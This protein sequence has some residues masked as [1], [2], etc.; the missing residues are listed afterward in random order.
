VTG[1]LLATLLGYV[2]RA[3]TLQDGVRAIGIGMWLALIMAFNVWFIIWPNQKKALGI[4]V[5]EAAEKAAAAKMA[6]MTSRANTMLSSMLWMMV[7]QQNRG[8]TVFLFS[9]VTAGRA[10]VILRESREQCLT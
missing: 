4:V 5:V 3:L 1:L 6:G 10:P 9:V 8:S 7:I 2:G